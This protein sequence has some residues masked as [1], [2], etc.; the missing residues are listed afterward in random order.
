[1][2]QFN[3]LCNKCV[4]SWRLD[5]NNLQY[6]SAKCD[7]LVRL[8]A[9]RKYLFRY[10]GEYATEFAAS[11]DTALKMKWSEPNRTILLE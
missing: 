11:V 6:L 3:L 10:C 4:L 8:F 7:S 2:V 1:M 9:A 5:T